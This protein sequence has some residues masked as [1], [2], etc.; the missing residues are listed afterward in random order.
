MV[1]NMAFESIN[2]SK[3]KSSIIACKK[4][5]NHSKTTML[6]DDLSNSN[7]W[8]SDSQ[9][10]LKR[11]LERLNNETYKKLEEKLDSYL[12][13]VSY[14]EQYKN[15]A[16]ENK[17]LQVEYSKL[18]VNLYHFD[19]GSERNQVEML[20]IDNMEKTIV[21]RQIDVVLSKINENSNQM[22]ILKNKVIN[23]I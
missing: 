20:V 14:I 16:E 6:I 1:F 15:L 17:N 7:V 13:A 2:V 22:E 5:L 9:I 19:Q 12:T 4:A 23:L 21:K 10:I 8:Q 3:L 11:S 18:K